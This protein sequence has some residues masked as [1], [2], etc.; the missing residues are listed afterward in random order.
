MS[1]RIIDGHSV[2]QWQSCRRRWL[3]EQ[4]W[5]VIRW[6]PKSLLDACLR[7]GIHALS[8]PGDASPASIVQTART[9]FLSQ[10]A[11]PGL[12]LPPGGD[13]WTIA[14]DL[15]G[16]I[17]TILTAIS[18]LTLLELRPQLSPVPVSSGISWQPL[19]WQD[20]SGMLHRWITVD[21]WD[22]AE[23]VRHL[24][25]WT[26]IG[27]MTMADAP[28]TLHAIEIGQRRRGRHQSPWCRAYRHP[29]IAKIVKF[30]LND[31]KGGHRALTG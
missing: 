25:S 13:S 20:E 7:R 1:V 12:D 15:C 3:L 24:H 31:G 4:S 16:M 9:E 18:R 11:N 5:S 21:A 2:T 28:L 19:S 8:Q 23:L 17:S 30:Q 29:A 14:N 10:A 6:R 26:V 27:D 22:D